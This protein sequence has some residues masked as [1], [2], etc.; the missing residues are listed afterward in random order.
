MLT[1][2]EWCPENCPPEKAPEKIAPR[3]NALQENWRA[4]FIQRKNKKF[5]FYGC[6]MADP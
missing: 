2:L 1:M 4:F 6:I 5:D 3:K